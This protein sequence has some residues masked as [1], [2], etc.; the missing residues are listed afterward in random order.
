V[1]SLGG[2]GIILANFG[3][4]FLGSVMSG[5][6]DRRASRLSLFLGSLGIIGEVTTEG[7]AGRS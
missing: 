2:L 6:N 1:H 4:I 5:A 7:Q 3:I